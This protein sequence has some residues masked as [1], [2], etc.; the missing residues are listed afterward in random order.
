MKRAL[1]VLYYEIFKLLKQESNGTVVEKPRIVSAINKKVS[2]M[3][4]DS[5]EKY[6]ER[7]ENVL[8]EFL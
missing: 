2:G 7:T 1:N 3:Y 5:T 6:V 4:M 8:R